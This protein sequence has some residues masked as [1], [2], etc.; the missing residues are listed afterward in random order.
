MRLL[1]SKCTVDEKIALSGYDDIRQRLDYP[2]KNKQTSL[3]LMCDLIAPQLLCARDANH[4]I[5]Q[6]N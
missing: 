6:N 4:L 3:A 5:F 1:F 2:K